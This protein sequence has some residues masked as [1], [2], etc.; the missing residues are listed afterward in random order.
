MSGSRYNK[1]MARA[2]LPI[3]SVSQINA[4]IKGAIEK[5]L[6]PRLM[7]KGQIMDWKRHQSGHCYFLLKDVDSQLPCVLWSSRY[8]KLKFRPE[9]GMEILAIGHVE[10]YVPQGKYQLYADELEPAGIGALQIAFEQM[11]AKLK[12]E[13]LFDERYKKPLPKFPMRIGILTSK[14]GAAVH[15]MADSILQRWPCA[16]LF[17]FDVP[18]QGEGAA[19]KIAQKLRWINRQNRCLKLDVL[20]VGRGG[21]SMEDLWAFNEEVLARAIFESKIPIISAVGHEIDTTIADLVA[22]ARA[23]TPTKAGIIAV[24]DRREVLHRL[25]MLSRR[26]E[27]LIRTRLESAHGRLETIL[28][29]W[30]FREPH[31][32][33]ERAW[34]LVDMRSL[35]LAGVM[36]QQITRLRQRLEQCG[37]VVRRLEPVRLIAGQR[38]RLERMQAMLGQSLAK[39]MEQ[40]RLQ[41]AAA[42]NKLTAMDPRAVLKRGYSITKNIRTGAVIRRVEEVQEGDEILTEL[43][44]QQ[45]LKSRVEERQP[46][47]GPEK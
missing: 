29:S 2:K 22:D 44:D 35:R 43:A 21:G 14:S 34:Q 13:G 20:I 19:E 18:V 46:S 38:I 32:L 24:P 16:K 9:N 8:Q 26:L 5:G 47:P 1:S 10:V 6:P 12:A 36:R 41:L 15:D 7:V 25:D 28:A 39:V 40:K 42:E 33:V 4:L 17:L 37:Q 23:S 27:Q 3:F 31:G 45:H 11:Y 30:V